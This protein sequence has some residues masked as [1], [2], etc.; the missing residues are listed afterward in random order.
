MWGRPEIEVCVICQN[1]VI[2]FHSI[3]RRVA[4]AG[5]ILSISW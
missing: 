4:D 1:D 5:G 2:K 3:E